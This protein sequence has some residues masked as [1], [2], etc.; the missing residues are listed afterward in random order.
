M[1]ELNVRAVLR[2][3]HDGS[4]ERALANLD[5]FLEMTRSYA[6][7]GLRAF[8]EAM[9]QAWDD[10]EK[11]GEGRPDAQ[12]DAVSLYTMHASKGLE[13]PVVIPVNTY[14]DVYNPSKPL[15][16]QVSR[17][18]LCKVFGVAPDG[19]DTVS[20]SEQAEIDRER[21]RLWYV[22]A[23]RAREMLVIPRCSHGKGS[24]SWI[25]VAKTDLASLPAIDLS[26][27]TDAM[28]PP[29]GDQP[30][31]QDSG[32]FVEQD[33]A[34]KAVTRSVKWKTPSRHDGEATVLVQEEPEITA[35]AGEEAEVAPPVEPVQGGR[36]RG[37]VMHKLF[38]EVLTGESPDDEPALAARARE[39][40]AELGTA[41]SADTAEGFSPDE[42]AKRVHAAVRLQEIAALRD[43]LVP[44]CHVYA[45]ESAGEDDTVTFGIADAV[46]IGAGGKA[47]TVIDWKSDVSPDA[48]TVAKYRSQ[49][50]DYL[51]AV[52]VP[53]GLIVFATTGTVVPVTT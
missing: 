39:L 11:A 36:V 31:A 34:I 43:R 33:K 22:A 46:A 30:N 13:W 37:L 48:A 29:A 26:V 1:D 47:E 35:D 53:Q 38:E 40:L 15:V 51:K 5:L 28:P 45:F 44:E 7:R 18:I 2:A 32:T 10:D 41:A 19:H 27:Y 21:V 42:I 23:T 20:Q 50:A 4:A 49:V 14:G 3:R 12:D 6:T 52:G 17:A 16:N 8:A 24:R 9:T 25:E